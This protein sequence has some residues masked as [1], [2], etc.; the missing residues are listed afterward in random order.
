MRRVD[1]ASFDGAPA[2]RERQGEKNP[3]RKQFGH[4]NRYC[5]EY[6]TEIL[7]FSPQSLSIPSPKPIVVTLLES[8]SVSGL[9]SNQVEKGKFHQSQRA[10]IN[11][12]LINSWTQ[13]IDNLFET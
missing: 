7:I 13:T 6:E 5:E 11:S 1:M 2:P 3:F 10:P 4:K 8:T 9:I 12:V